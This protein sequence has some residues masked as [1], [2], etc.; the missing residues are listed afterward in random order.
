MIMLRILYRWRIHPGMEKDFA[1][2]WEAVTRHYLEHHNSKGSRLH[3]GDDGLFYAYA[4]WP[5]ASARQRA[6]AADDAMLEPYREKM[7]AAIAERFPE[8]ELE[9]V[10]DHIEH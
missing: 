10:T 8:V 3:V 5:D 4:Q 7:R 6:F 2:A 9:T 1:E